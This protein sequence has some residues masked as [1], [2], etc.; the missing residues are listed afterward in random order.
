M[1]P[2]TFLFR[3]RFALLQHPPP[4]HIGGRLIQST[5]GLKLWEALLFTTCTVDGFEGKEYV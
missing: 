2:Y 4:T 5:P 3:H 1:H